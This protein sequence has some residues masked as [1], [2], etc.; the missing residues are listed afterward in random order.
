MNQ[1]V[2]WS[3]A[4]LGLFIWMLFR[5]YATAPWKILGVFGLLLLSGPLMVATLKASA[6]AYPVKYDYVLQSL[7]ES[8]GLTAFQVARLF[9]LWER[10]ILIAVYDLLGAA[11]V[12]WYGVH[13]VIR[14]GQSRKLLY[15]YFILYL[16][17]AALY[18]IVP[19]MGPR[20]AFSAT[21]PVGHPTFVA[22]P[23]PLDGYPNA[24]P[25][26]HMATASL[27]VFFN[28]RNRWLLSIAL[29][30][31]SATVGATLAL[32]HYVIDLIVAVPLTCFGVE[33]AYGRV[34]PAMKYLAGVLG[35]LLLIRFASPGLA[36]HPWTLRLMA[37]STV[38]VG[39]HAIAV[40]WRTEE[41]QSPHESLIVEACG[42]PERSLR[43]LGS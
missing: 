6:H 8:L 21:F 3:F 17:G 1:T 7:D 19:A 20:Y 32:E 26:L 13:L 39:V 43:N 22:T 5:P 16:V 2:V 18:G 14:G 15:A 35:W 31:L 37:A 38:A 12:A 29:L 4:I 36:Q 34:I 11:M 27:L 9:N 42:A 10:T 33:L 23:V 28:N 40:R 30:F 25:S 24:M 41:E